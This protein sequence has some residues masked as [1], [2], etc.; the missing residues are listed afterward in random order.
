MDEEAEAELEQSAEEEE[1]A[2]EAEDGN[3]MKE[4]EGEEGEAEEE[5]ADSHVNDEEL[6]KVKLIIMCDKT[7]RE[8]FA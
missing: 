7:E 1:N 4:F 8:R 6:Y 5:A 2:K 3:E